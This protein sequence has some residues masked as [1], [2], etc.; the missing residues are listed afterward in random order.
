MNSNLNYKIQTKKIED[1]HNTDY[2]FNKFNKK[3]LKS[4]IS[5]RSIE[6]FIRPYSDWNQISDILLEELWKNI[7]KD[8]L[9]LLCFLQSPG[10]LENTRIARYKKLHKFYS[11]D[12]ELTFIFQKEFTFDKKIGYFGIIDLANQIHTNLIEI[13][14]Y[15]ENG[16]LFTQN[17]QKSF[18]R[19]EI[20]NIFDQKTLI[21]KKTHHCQ[22]DL[23][24]TI[25]DLT[26]QGC[27]AIYLKSW[28]ETGSY[29]LEIFYN[30][31]NR[32]YLLDNSE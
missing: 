22:L 21:N 19:D 16:I 18:N 26:N 32:E 12:Q 1:I 6:L 17:K 10:L 20:L 15:Q 30:K 14:S 4:N 28:P 3:D 9:K 29:F 2:E 5:L 13:L 23:I 27:L 25:K 11:M 7:R 8:D 24:P 31:Q